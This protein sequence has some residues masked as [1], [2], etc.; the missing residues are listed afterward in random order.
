M[1]RDVAVCLEGDEC[2]RAVETMELSQVRRVP[3]V[4]SDGRL[5]G[6]IAQADVARCL[7][8]SEKVAH[9]LRE[10]SRPAGIAN[11]SWR[12]GVKYCKRG[13]LAV[14]S[15]AAGASLMYLFDPARGKS[16]RRRLVERAQSTAH[17]AGKFMEGIKRNIINRTRG[18]AAETKFALQNEPV[19]DEKLVSRIR[20]KLGHLTSH[21]HAI[22]VSVQSGRVTLRGPILTTEV[23]GLLRALA[24]IPGVTNVE[25][26]LEMHETPAGVPLLQVGSAVKPKRV[27]WRPFLQLLGSIG[28][29]L[30]AQAIEEKKRTTG[31]SRAKPA[32]A[33]SKSEAA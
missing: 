12:A 30:L 22:E 18:I 24:K 7:E 10:I 16:R 13:A 25:N 21:P 5:V 20:A 23:H 3:V 1:I 29:V 14:A 19:S 8:D 28:L 4:D 31:R 27:S 9:M 26:Q 17:H 2:Q 33:H 6:I 11:H 15:M 32:E